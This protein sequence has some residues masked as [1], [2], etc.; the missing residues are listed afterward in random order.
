MDGDWKPNPGPQ[1]DFLS[2][3]AFEVL[4]GGAAGGGKATRFS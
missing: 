2:R 4:Y 1:T 3:T